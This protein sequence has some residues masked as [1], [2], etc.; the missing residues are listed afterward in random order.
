MEQAG[1][2]S[3]QGP[4][5]AL[6]FSGRAGEYFR[7]WIVNV[8]LSV[9]TLGIYSAWAKVRRKRYFYGCTRLGGAAFEYLGNPVAILK[10]RVL[11]VAVLVAYSLANETVPLLGLGIGLV[12]FVLLPWMIVRSLQFNARNSSLRNVRFAFHGRPGEAFKL[13]LLS[14]FGTALS[15]GLVYPYYLYRKRRYFVEHSAYGGT[16]FAFSARAGQYYMAALKVA[17]GFL[18]FVVGSLVTLGIGLIPFY[19]LLR[20]YAQTTF[21][22][23]DWHHATLG[24]I[25][26][27]CR[28][29][30]VAL[31]WLYLVNSLAIVFSLGLL[32]PWAAVR[33]AK[34]KLERMS[35]RPAER[36]SAILA[37]AGEHVGALGDEAGEFLG[38]DFGL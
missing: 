7:I 9:L 6:E 3:Q 36:L 18:A 10:G 13:L 38:F 8:C 5:T 29:Q 37:A 25:G 28:W 26:F 23:L 22:R 15:L 14:T 17:A 33:T 20:S 27:E 1:T 30:A 16:R 21:A 2:V 12:L 31:F 24:E 35:V 19:I 4:A 11:V 32:G 34:Y